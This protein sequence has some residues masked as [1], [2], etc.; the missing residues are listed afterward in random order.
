MGGTLLPKEAHKHYSLWMKLFSL[1][2]FGNSLATQCSAQQLGTERWREAQS[3]QKL[4]WLV[5]LHVTDRWFTKWSSNF[6]P[7]LPNALY[8]LY[9]VSKINVQEFKEVF[10]LAYHVI[11]LTGVK[12]TLVPESAWSQ[13]EVTFFFYYYYSKLRLS[14]R[15]QLHKTMTNS[16]T[17]INVSPVFT[18]YLTLSN[19][20]VRDICR[21]IGRWCWSSKPIAAH[22]VAILQK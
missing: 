2:G 19:G 16:P 15:E 5:S 12:V 8:G 13:C 9:S 10:H 18:A 4:I 14:A 11:G 20:T 17:Q 7:F 22:P 1:T 21:F 3:K 6:W